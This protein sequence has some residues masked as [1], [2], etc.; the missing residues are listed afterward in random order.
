MLC[1][2]GNVLAK[3]GVESAQMMVAAVLSSRQH[4]TQLC[5]SD[6]RGAVRGEQQCV[7][8]FPRTPNIPL[9]EL[10]K[11]PGEKLLPLSRV[12]KSNQPNQETKRRV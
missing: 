7:F 11:K 3:G 1:P 2:L 8:P 5:S 9:R 10:G 4:S 12:Q 6:W